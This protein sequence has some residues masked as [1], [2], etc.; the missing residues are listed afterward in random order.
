MFPGLVTCLG[1]HPRLL[2]DG[3]GQGDLRA[4]QGLTETQLLSPAHRQ[5]RDLDPEFHPAGHGSSPRRT[6][7]PFSLFF[8]GALGT[9]D[10]SNLRAAPL[11]NVLTCRERHPASSTTHS[12]DI[13]YCL[14]GTVLSSGDPAGNKADSL[15]GAP[16]PRCGA[17]RA[18]ISHRST[19]PTRPPQGQTGGIPVPG[20]P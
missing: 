12:T 4:G 13:L 3:Q 20:L 6:L 17:V 14:P 11:R 2:R 15:R 5:M 9:G 1:G 7:L 19:G 18:L 10:S 16:R 8:Q